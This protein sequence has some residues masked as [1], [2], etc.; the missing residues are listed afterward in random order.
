MRKNVDH[1]DS[2]V[3]GFCISM[4]DATTDQKN[5]KVW[6]VVTPDPNLDQKNIT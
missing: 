3:Y 6:H 4:Q 5:T 2:A 1:A